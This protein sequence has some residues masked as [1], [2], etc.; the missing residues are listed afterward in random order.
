MK[1]IPTIARIALATA[2]AGLC[3]CLENSS[4]DGGDLSAVSAESCM[5]CHNGA[6]HDDYA[7]KGLENPHPF[8]GAATL[9]CTECHGGNPGA[10]G[11]AS[12]SHVPPPPEIGNANFQETNALAYFN[13]LTLAGIDKFADYEVKGVTYKA[14]DYLQFVNP[15][16]LRVVTQGRGCGKCHAPHAE[17]SSKSP[18]ATEMGI[19]SSS[20]YTLGLQNAVPENQGLF[21][22]TASD[23]SFREVIEANY[24]VD[25]TKVGVV[26]RL[27]EFPVYSV[28]GATGPTAIFNNPAYDSANLVNSL[29]ADNSVIPGSPLA[30]LFH[31]QVAFT[32][33]DCHL[34][35]SGAN[36]RYGDFRSSG[37][38]ACHMRYSQDGRSR[39]T[40]KNIKK[41]E[42]ANVDAID[43]PERP[44]VQRH[45]IK[46]IARTL[47]TGETVEGI[48][49]YTCAGCHQG[50]NR[51]VMQY[52]G[53]RL[54]QNADLVHSVQYPANPVRFTTTQLDTRLF[55]PAV[56]NRTFNGRNPNQYILHED[57]DGDGR[58]DTPADIHYEAGLGCIDCHGSHDV[59]GGK[60]GDPDATPIMSR[61]EQAVAI[62]CESCHGSI[63]AYAA[64]AP[65]V[66]YDGIAAE[67]AVDA[68]GN[69]IKNVT[70]D[71][72]GNYYLKSR[73][74]ARIHF[75]RQT[76]D[77]VADSGKTNP[78]NGQPV[79]SA[80]ASYAMGRIDADP[81]NGIGPQQTN[82]TMTHAGFA[83][84]DTMSCVA[85]H[86]SWTNNCIGCHLTG[87]YNTGNNF[88]NITGERIVY[89]Q[90]T[91]DFTYQT[92]VPFQLGVSTHDEIS[93]ISP[94]TL[95][96]YKWLDRNRVLSQEF[97]FS[98][99]HGY[100]NNPG[101]NGQNQFP[102]LS[103]NVMMPH[104]IRGKVTSQNEGTRYCVAC[105]LTTD[106]LAS[107]GL[108]YDAFR[109]AMASND[110]AS[111]DF[112]FLKT[113]I[114]QNPGNQ[115]NSPIWVHM[116]AGLGSGMFLFDADGCP[117]N[118]LDDNPNRIGCNLT[119]PADKFDL[120]RVRLN[121]DRI[122]EP[123]GVPN[124]SNNHALLE[125]GA[126]S[127]LR[128]G[129]P[130][131]Q[132]AG[133]LG[134]TLI[135]RLTDPVN[136][137]VL[138]AWIDADGQLQ[139]DASNFVTP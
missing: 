83:H 86:A 68:A 109:T 77:V 104:S 22:D 33:G 16:D 101:V 43:E 69:V 105:H 27:M 55:D 129:A 75:I 57:Y 4:H 91:A 102:A 85:C 53:I 58:D 6:S 110:F 76:K 47:A 14:L 112:N 106:G 12:G 136:G 73:L 31:E 42:P 128:D 97:F 10:H 127:T 20:M 96:F 9:K 46:S 28:F 65:C 133:P 18:L 92:P 111:L 21:L 79:F 54:D 120:A 93:V 87:E 63:D 39:S 121:L 89:K 113:H 122:V 13:R 118:P 17:S 8:P 119:S 72:G 95:V 138:D 41:K 2:A 71:S 70:K 137:I 19:L 36:N 52:W 30:N 90:A 135:R 7:G 5:S 15:G 11:S 84:S 100:G 61:Q 130:N 59:H 94:N 37:C 117:T 126:T 115:F 24:T 88:S 124:S 116:V 99:R 38:S 40:D 123:T 114:G 26:G 80:K 51:T 131:P 23:Y 66:T 107:F 48:D 125:G 67:C 103:H 35:S 1:I 98:D 50:S 29:N 3:G 62:R 78:L 82:A 49:D 132:F 81:S 74:N 32:C 64:T 34:G 56:E 44:H 25:P 139:G 108:Q 134:A 60:V 45:M